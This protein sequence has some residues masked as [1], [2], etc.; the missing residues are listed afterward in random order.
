M[1]DIVIS[2]F[3]VFGAVVAFTNGHWIIGSILVFWIFMPLK[4]VD[5]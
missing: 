1:G 3:M 2:A 4:G 5:F